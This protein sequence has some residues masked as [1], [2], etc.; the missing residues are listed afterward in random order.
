VDGRLHPIQ[1][2]E[3]APKLSGTYVF[4]S[5]SRIITGYSSL[6]SSGLMINPFSSSLLS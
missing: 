2:I 3:P 4:P 6:R 1:G 5:S